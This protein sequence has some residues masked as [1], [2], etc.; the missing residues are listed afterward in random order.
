MALA[1]HRHL[2]TLLLVAIIGA[3]SGGFVGAISCG[4]EP[5]SGWR[6]TA[7][8]V[9]EAQEYVAPL[10][11]AGALVRYSCE[12]HEAVMTPAGWNGM[13]MNGKYEVTISL[14]TICASQN[15]GIRMT[16]FDAQSGKNFARVSSLSGY[17]EF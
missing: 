2:L 1:F 15:H 17:E 12:S 5:N 8:E 3:C 10:Q 7:Q 13:K 11:K 16:I 4:S 14:S 6:P 9:A